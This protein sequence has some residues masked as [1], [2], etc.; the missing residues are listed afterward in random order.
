[1]ALGLARI[2]AHYFRA[3]V[4]STGHDLLE[5]VDRIRR[6]PAL[7]H[8]GALRHGCPIVSADG[9]ARAWAEAEY[10]MVADAGHWMEPGIA[11]AGRGDR[12]AQAELVAPTSLCHAS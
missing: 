8:T 4:I 12:E 5:A 10:T 6:I 9:L 1:M 11:P 2:E 3:N 7:H